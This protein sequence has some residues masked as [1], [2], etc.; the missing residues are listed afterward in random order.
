[1]LS[2]INE[3][4]LDLGNYVNKKNINQIEGPYKLIDVFE[5]ILN[6]D[7]QQ[8]GTGLKLLTRN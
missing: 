1:M 8:Y 2:M 5:R 7:K 4:I 3:A 6:F